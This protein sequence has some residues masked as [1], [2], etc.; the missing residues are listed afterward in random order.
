MNEYVY[1]GSMFTRDGRCESDI[2]R[3]KTAGAKVSGALRPIMKSRSVSI[4]AKK[5]M[6]QAILLPTLM[7]GSESWT[8]LKKDECG[9][10]A[11]EMRS[12]RRMCG[13][14][15]RD[16]VRNTEIREMCDNEER[17]NKYE[18]E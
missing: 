9:I 16:R 5:L 2:E 8:W 17:Y 4:P 18:S 10:N 11:V 6:H 3:R 1:L 13:R 14:T 15:L 12:L 7:Y